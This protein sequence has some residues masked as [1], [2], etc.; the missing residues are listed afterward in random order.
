MRFFSFLAPVSPTRP[1]AY[2]AYYA[3]YYSS[4]GA[5]AGAAYAAQVKVR[6]LVPR[7]RARKCLT[8]CSQ[9]GEGYTYS[10]AVTGDVAPAATGKKPGAQ[11]RTI[12]SAHAGYIDA[13][14]RK[15]ANSSCAQARE[16]VCVCCGRVCSRVAFSQR[17]RP[18][19]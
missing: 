15:A 18:S 3:A 4:Q 1:P 5:N 9:S 10:Y 16:R 17:P 13:I 8:G 19:K 11:P 6:E 2:A 14:N 7:A 12:K